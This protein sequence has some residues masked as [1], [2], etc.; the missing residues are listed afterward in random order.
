MFS[1]HHGSAEQDIDKFTEK[2]GL[3]FSLLL[4]AT[5]NAAFV[6]V[7]SVIV[8]F[9][10]P[11]AAGSGIPQIKCFLNGVKIPHVVRLKVPGWPWGVQALCRV[12]NGSVV[13]LGH[14]VC[15]YAEC[16]W[17]L[18]LS[19]KSWYLHMLSHVKRE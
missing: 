4:W 5:L 17:A 6:L 16:R 14:L 12:G 19:G 10:E 1:E 3:S 18:F 2:G 15:W 13:C 8:A 7:G 9:I 11:V